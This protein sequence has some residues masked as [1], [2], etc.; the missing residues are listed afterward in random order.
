MPACL[1]LRWQPC[2]QSI[3]WLWVAKM[4]S[5]R[6]YF[7]RSAPSVHYLFQR[8]FLW[9]PKTILLTLSLKYTATQ[10]KN[11]PIATIA[12]SQQHSFL[13]TSTC[14]PQR[15][16]KSKS[17]HKDHRLAKSVLVFDVIERWGLDICKQALYIQLLTSKRFRRKS[18]QTS[19]TKGPKTCFSTQ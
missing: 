15:S 16:N 7:T 14:W 4:G 17:W 18:V 9:L 13:I 6:S 10:W 19:L 12:K 8:S 11:G 2:K 3:N 5:S 1:V